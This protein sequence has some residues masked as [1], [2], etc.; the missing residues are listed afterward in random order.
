M[1]FLEFHFNPKLAK[2]KGVIFDTFCFVP[3]KKEEEKFG[4]LYLIGELKNV[5]PR[6]QNLLNKLAEIVHK[7]YYKFAERSVGESFKESLARANE[8]LAQEVK[9]ENV[10]WLGN[11]NMA[12]VSFSQDFL[13]NL[14]KVGKLKILLLRDKEI[15]DVG[16]NIREVSSCE[17]TFSKAIEG[18]LSQG[19]KLLLLTSEVFEIFQTQGIIEK[20]AEIKKIKEI[21]KILKE[22]KKILKEIFGAQL[23]IIPQKKS[24]LFKKICLPQPVFLSSLPERTRKNL[25]A[26]LVLIILLLLGWLIFK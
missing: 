3:K 18:K 6:T 22:K 7:E 26:I 17:R 13:L 8:F 23:V 16:G 20:L 2:K 5:L 14:A 21:K 9:K 12:I 4:Y 1:K 10:S 24:L 25:I 15:F 11:L 19:D